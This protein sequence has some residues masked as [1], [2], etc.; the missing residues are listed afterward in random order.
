[1][2][3]KLHLHNKF[4]LAPRG[5]IFPLLNGFHRRLAEDRAAPEQLG[6]LNRAIGCNHR[7][8]SDHATDVETFQRLGI[9]GLYAIDNFSLN[10]RLIVGLRSQWLT[11]EYCTDKDDCKKQASALR[12]YATA[13]NGTVRHG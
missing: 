11:N 1:M 4:F 13:R 9:F 3:V 8:H 7:F 12:T 6:S 5:R 10:C 2:G